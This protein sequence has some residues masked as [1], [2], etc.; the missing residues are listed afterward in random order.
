MA[1][2]SSGVI[3][4]CRDELAAAQVCQCR[5]GGAFG[6]PSGVGDRAHTG[7]DGAPFISCSLAIKI[8]INDK[9]GGLLIVPDQIAHQH[10]ENVIVDGNALL[11]T[12]H[13]ERMREE[14][15]R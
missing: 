2:C 1:W 13:K 4:C 14:E 12:G 15:K 3:G 9:R 7:A 10:V 6:K 8:Q 5:V 11:E